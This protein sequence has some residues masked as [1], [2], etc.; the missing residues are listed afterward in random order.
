VFRL[1][2]GDLVGISAKL[3]GRDKTFLMYH[4]KTQVLSL[5]IT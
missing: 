4:V 3:Q 5:P 2:K 1:W